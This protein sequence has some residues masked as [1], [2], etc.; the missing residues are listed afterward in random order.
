MA[1]LLV[2]NSCESNS[3]SLSIKLIDYAYN[4]LPLPNETQINGK[5]VKRNFELKLHETHTLKEFDIEKIKKGIIDTTFQY[6]PITI[7][8]G[9]TV[10][11]N[12]TFQIGLIDENRNGIFNDISIDKLI[13]LPKKTDSI[14]FDPLTYAPVTVLK[15]ETYIR[16]NDNEY[17]ARP[18][19][20]QVELI[21]LR[22][23]PDTIHCTFNSRIPNIDIVDDQ[24]K[25]MKLYELKEPN[26]NLIVELWFNGCRGCIKTLPELKKIDKLSNTIVSL[27]VVDELTTINSFKNKHKI[28]WK[29]I[30]GNKTDLMKIGNLGNYPSAIIY[31]QEGEL[32]NLSKTY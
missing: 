14:C 27:N 5:V 13:L 18:G 3:K 30:K 26:K 12:N 24:G 11:E 29:M 21:R 20:D 9:E 22:D 15:D 31:D 10:I 32:I 28:D 4:Q 23:S 25:T 17:L 19:Q 8:K 7:R 16:I 1:V 2:I 6:Y